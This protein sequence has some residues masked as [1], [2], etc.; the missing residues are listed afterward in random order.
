MRSS[1]IISQLV[2]IF[3]AS[4]KQSEKEPD[5]AIQKLNPVAIEATGYPVPL[6]S[7]P[8]W[9]IVPLENPKFI[10]AGNPAVIKANSNVFIAGLPL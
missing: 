5:A 7:M 2:F 8:K 4:C 1:F 6:D 3:V 9:K 10:P